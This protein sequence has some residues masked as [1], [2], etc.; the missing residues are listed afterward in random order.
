MSL[1]L[2]DGDRAA[3]GEDL[4]PGHLQIDAADVAVD[5]LD[6]TARLRQ[7]FVDLLQLNKN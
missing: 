4:L 3:L 2:L 5:E 7:R 1:Q 6:R